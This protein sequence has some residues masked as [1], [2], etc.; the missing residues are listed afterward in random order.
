MDSLGSTTPQLPPTAAIIRF[1]D[2]ANGLG[3]GSMPRSRMLASLAP[4]PVDD[5]L[6]DWEL[7]RAFL[8][9]GAAPPAS[10]A[11][12]KTAVIMPWPGPRRR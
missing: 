7:L 1:Q 5:D 6:D 4:P 9:G 11:L 8:R 3:R 10:V 2:F 12:S